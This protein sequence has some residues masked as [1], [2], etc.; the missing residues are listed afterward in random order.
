MSLRPGKKLTE[1]QRAVQIERG[2]QPRRHP[3]QRDEERICGPPHLDQQHNQT[4]SGY[5]GAKS[6]NA[7]GTSDS[8]VPFPYGNHGRT[9]S[10]QQS[11]CR[12]N[13]IIGDIVDRQTADAR[14]IRSLA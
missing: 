5:R 14:P 9:I 7:N 2:K 13:R 3:V 12:P 8:E 1:P 10:S 4:L 6:V 11:I